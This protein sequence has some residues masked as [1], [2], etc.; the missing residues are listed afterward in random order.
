MIKEI[1]DIVSMPFTAVLTCFAIWIFYFKFSKGIKKLKEREEKVK[2]LEELWDAKFKSIFWR[3]YFMSMYDWKDL[4]AGV[5]QESSYILEDLMR[6]VK[7]REE[8]D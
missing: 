8:D 2:A 1:T 5:Y 3:A 4:V 6:R 7:A